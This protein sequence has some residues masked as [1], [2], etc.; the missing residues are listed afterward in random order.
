[1]RIR[2]HVMRLDNPSN[3]PLGVYHSTKGKY[4]NQRCFLTCNHVAL[5]VCTI[6]WKVYKL[7]AT[8]KLLARWPSHSIRVTTCNLLHCQ[9]VSDT[10]IQACLRWRSNSFL[11][12]LRNMLYAAAAHTKAIHIPTSHLPRLTMKYKLIKLPGGATGVTNLAT[13]I[14]ALTRFQPQEDFEQ[15]RSTHAA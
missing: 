10:Y 11:G 7:K 4:A 1:M 12:Y 9:G 6:A 8:D 14:L 15:I 2:L 5:F 3:E 13:A